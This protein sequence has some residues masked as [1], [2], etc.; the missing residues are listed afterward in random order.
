MNHT[1]N[2][3][4]TA[5]QPN[6]ALLYSR[7]PY[8]RRRNRGTRASG[9]SS[10]ATTMMLAA[11]PLLQA[12]AVPATLCKTPQASEVIFAGNELSREGIVSQHP[13]LGR[14]ARSAASLS[15]P[16]YTMGMNAVHGGHA[17]V[18]VD[19]ENLRY[20][21]CKAGFK[22]DFKAF[23]DRLARSVGRVSAHAYSTAPESNCSRLAGYFHYAGY[24]AHIQAIETVQT[25]HGPRTLANSDNQI[26]LGLAEN[27]ARLQPDVLV[28]VTGDGDL[29]CAV[30]KYLAEYSDRAPSLH[31]AS[32]RE[33]TSKRLHAQNNTGIAGN[34][35]LGLDLMRPLA[36]RIT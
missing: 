20:G 21:L 33:T 24:A 11:F 2:L 35:W 14:P 32:V 6:K 9:C 19:V 15:L 16:E 26:L 22:L 13:A 28:L 27:V 10:I 25:F 29:G 4:A 36:R 5:A 30:S 31:I 8:L 17:L 7:H 1:D 3:S 34:I 18:I 12:S 23:G